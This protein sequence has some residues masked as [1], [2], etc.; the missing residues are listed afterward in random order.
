MINDVY[1]MM[2]VRVTLQMA[3][4]TCVEREKVRQREIIDEVLNCS[5]ESSTPHS[6]CDPF[7][8]EQNQVGDC[9]GGK[10]NAGGSRDLKGL[11]PGRQYSFLAGESKEIGEYGGLISRQV[12]PFVKS[13]MVEVSGD[14]QEKSYFFFHWS[15]PELAN[16]LEYSFHVSRGR[17]EL[18]RV[19]PDQRSAMK[20]LLRHSHRHALKTARQRKRT[21]QKT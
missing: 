3:E 12:E 6:P 15:N 7:P 20:K 5:T 19:W 8:H 1:V 2:S 9:E 4:V 14:V 21:Q 13:R 10:E 17:E 18:E 11:F 16:R